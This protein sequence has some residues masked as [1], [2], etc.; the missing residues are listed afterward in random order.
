MEKLELAQQLRARLLEKEL[1]SADTVFYVSDDEVINSYN[2]CPDCGELSCSDLELSGI[3]ERCGSAEEFIDEINR[4]AERQ[5]NTELKQL[6]KRFRSKLP[7]Y[8]VA[9]AFYFSSIDELPKHED[10]TVEPER[11]TITVIRTSDDEPV[12][13]IQYLRSVEESIKEKFLECFGQTLDE[14]PGPD[15]ICMEPLTCVLTPCARSEC[16]GFATRYVST[17]DYLRTLADEEDKRKKRHVKSRRRKKS[18]RK[19]KKH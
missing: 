16:D 5:H 6:K 12:K 10:D 8:I 15:T 13:E 7:K 2:K 19:P 1:V 18:G 11:F 17:S 14:F 3:I 4:I 9:P